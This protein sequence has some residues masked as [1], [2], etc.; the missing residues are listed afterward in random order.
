[1]GISVGTSPD[2]EDDGDRFVEHVSKLA[3][4]AR[5]LE[6]AIASAAKTYA[7]QMPA[8]SK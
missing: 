8:M 4:E 3:D 2:P 5:E 1:M 7:R 6:R